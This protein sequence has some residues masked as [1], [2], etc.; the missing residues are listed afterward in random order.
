[1]IRAVAPAASDRTVE[2]AA[3]TAEA[4]ATAAPSGHLPSRRLPL[5]TLSPT[6]GGGCGGDGCGGDGANTAAV[7]TVT[8][9]CLTISVP[10]SPGHPTERSEGGHQLLVRSRSAMPL[11][12]VRSS[13]SRQRDAL[14]PTIPTRGDVSDDSQTSSSGSVAPCRPRSFKKRR[15]SG[16]TGRRWSCP[17]SQTDPSRSQCHLWDQSQHRS[18]AD[19]T[20]HSL[21]GSIIVIDQIRMH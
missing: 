15:R 7:V 14:F 6:L 4:A 12:S 16:A 20:I 21:P 17:E 1:M 9:G 3:A 18:Q 5:P 19:L 11:R 2:A 8:A 10:P 13:S